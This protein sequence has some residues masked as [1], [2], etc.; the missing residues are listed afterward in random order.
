MLN[1][2]DFLADDSNLIELRNKEVKLRLL[3]KNL[4]AENEMPIKL[5]NVGVP[6]L[7]LLIFGIAKF[8]IR[9]RRYAS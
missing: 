8:A 1:M 7:L 5:I 2:I 4:I 6:I 9:K 3:D